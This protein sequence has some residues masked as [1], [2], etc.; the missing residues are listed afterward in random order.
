MSQRFSQHVVCESSQSQH[1]TK[2]RFTCVETHLFPVGPFCEET[3]QLQG[4]AQW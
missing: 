2:K 1:S 4:R 3:E